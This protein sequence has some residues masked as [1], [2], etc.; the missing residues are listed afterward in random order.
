MDFIF[1]PLISTLVIS[2]N[3]NEKSF[4][5]LLVQTGGFIAVLWFVIL[6]IGKNTSRKLYD[7]NLVSYLY[8]TKYKPNTIILSPQEI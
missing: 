8:F 1:N 7:A 6:P 3:K 2:R 5:D 4:M